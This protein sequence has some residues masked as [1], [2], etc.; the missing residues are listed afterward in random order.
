VQTIALGNVR[1]HH[2]PMIIMFETRLRAYLV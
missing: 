1:D 2:H